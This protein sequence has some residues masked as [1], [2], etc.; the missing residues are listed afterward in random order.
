MKKNI[1]LF[2]VNY[3][4]LDFYRSDKEEKFSGMWLP[5]SA[6]SVWAYSQQFPHI[7]E[8][9]EISDCFFQREPVEEVVGRLDNPSICV[10]SCYVWNENYNLILSESIK[11]KYPECIIAF[12]GPQVD[13]N[14]IDFLERNSF[15]DS[16][17]INEGEVLFYNLLND[18]LE[19]GKVKRCY[20]SDRIEDLDIPSAYDTGIMDK[21]LK[22]NP[23][24][25]WSTTIETNRGCP[26][27]CTFCE[28]GTSTQGKLKQ[29][30]LE[31]VFRDIDWCCEN[32]I[33]YIVF[34]DAN[35]GIFFERDKIIAEYLVEAKKKT[36]FPN[37]VNFSWNKN[38]NEHTIELI[39]ILNE[40][41]LHRGLTLSVQSLNDKTLTAIKRKNMEISKLN[42]IFNLC[43]KNNINYY[44]EFILGM[45]YETYESWCDGL[46]KALENH[47][48][49]SLEIYLLEVLRNSELVQQLD[50]H[51]MEVFNYQIVQEGQLSNISEKHNFVISTKYMSVE[52]LIDSWMYG[53]MI[54]NFHSYGWTQIISR[55][56]YELTGKSYREIY[57]NFL[58]YIHNNQ[59]LSKYFLEFKES[60]ERFLRS[61]T[62]TCLKEDI[63]VVYDNNRFHLDRE[64]IQ[65]EV[66]KWGRLLLNEVDDEVVKDTLKLQNHYV[67]NYKDK[68][69]S[70]VYLKYNIPELIRN[71]SEL[72]INPKVYTLHNVMEWDGFKD[73]NTKLYYRRMS[74]FGK[75]KIGIE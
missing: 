68:L 20:R 62:S 38:N 55:V 25:V 11:K 42:K 56:A 58:E 8:N 17:M 61:D 14:G 40:V 51:K 28:W 2:Q 44:T 37:N 22:E 4:I 9:Y 53:W 52:Q 43:N 34:G 60:F 5:Y 47:C 1:Y 73:F 63:I 59:I 27:R 21:L 45:P 15:V 69:D 32:K 10:F 50:E 48:H 26:Y 46:C 75:R 23:N 12:G 29:F 67:M 7:T 64:I 66:E 72:K 70:S 65:Q 41:G 13:E 18:H 71:Q 33:D 24:V 6:V 35:F 19:S 16:V 57:E 49:G 39:N 3:Q 31:R 36:G 74:G 54:I 30:N